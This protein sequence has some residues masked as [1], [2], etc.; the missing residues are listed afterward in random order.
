MRS[1]FTERDGLAYLEL[2]LPGDEQTRLPLGM[3]FVLFQPNAN[4]WLKNGGK[5]MYV[6]LL[7]RPADPRLPTARLWDLA[8]TIVGAEMGASS[9]TL[10]H[11][12]NLCH[13]LLDQAVQETGT[14]EDSLSL[15]FAWL[16][17]SQIRQLDWQRHFNTKPRE[18]AHAQDR[19]TTRLAGIFRK[20]MAASG[21]DSSWVR[22]WLRLML[23]TLGRGGDGQRVRDEILHIMHRRGLKETSGSFMEEWHQKLHNNTTP[24]DV[25]LC[26]AFLAFLKSNGDL[27]RFYQVLEAGGVTRD[28]L[29]SFER[30][31]VTEPRFFADQKDGL[32]QDFEAFLAVLNSVHSGTDLESA[33]AAA[34][35][36]L[37][38]A[39][40]K[41]LDQLLPSRQTRG[42]RRELLPVLTAVREGVKEAMRSARD[43]AALRDL[44]FLDL[45]LEN[46]LRGMMERDNLSQL[47]RDGLV[48]RLLW[49]LRNLG[50]A[51]DEPELA[52]CASHWA[53]LLG[54]PREGRDWALHA[55]SV[56]DRVSR[57]LRDFSNHLYQHLQPRAEFLG[58][59]FEA[60][61]WTVSL[62]SEEI[63][64]G[65]AVFTLSLLLRP[66][67]VL[68][69]CAAGLGG[70]QVV[71][72]GRAAGR[73]RVV[74]R[75]LAVQGERFPEPVVLIADTVQGVEEIPEGVTAVITTDTPDLV[76]HV[77]VRARN[78]H[79]LFASCLEPGVYEQLEGTQG[80]K[81]P[82]AGNPVRRRDV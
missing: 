58:E 32:I 71:S 35:S 16:R 60:D 4:T 64:R 12:F 1:P 45:G 54:K 6:P 33:A 27:R 8:E 69:R 81:R 52:L 17:Y 26:S 68:L 23:T 11:R 65:S 42:T 67:D 24:D 61:A 30:P 22:T 3:P 14:D 34:A 18:L 62:F 79:V 55:K 10:M 19:L 76:S 82:H 47:G 21:A 75:L 40:K 2:T 49:V 50:L 53:L 57:W 63:V 31:I 41:Q 20:S 66:L 29:K 44:L 77:A 59:A 9:W 39:V 13:D 80:Q 51:L 36:R 7:R 25:V 46:A 15:L 73:V 72:P 70:W 5:D 43:D 74:D 38:D 37:S 78:A 56:A 48:E 28:R